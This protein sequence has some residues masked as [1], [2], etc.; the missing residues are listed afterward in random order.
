MPL[1]QYDY[2][3]LTGEKQETEDGK[4]SQTSVVVISIGN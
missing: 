4:S 3:S 1:R 2:F